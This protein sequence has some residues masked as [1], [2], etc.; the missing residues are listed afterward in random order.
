MPRLADS[1]EPRAQEGASRSIR[2]GETLIARNH[3]AGTNFLEACSEAMRERKALCVA[4]A[5]TISSKTATFR[6]SAFGLRMDIP[7]NHPIRNSSYQPSFSAD[8]RGLPTSS[9]GAIIVRGNWSGAIFRYLSD[10][11]CRIHAG[12][13][14]S[15]SG[16]GEP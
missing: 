14:S 10:A 3:S 2:P 8:C 15:S 12:P 4:K 5:K 7:N 16:S 11:G 13:G 1:R 6:P 9:A